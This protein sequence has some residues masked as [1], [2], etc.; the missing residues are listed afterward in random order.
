MDRQ[1]VTHESHTTIAN[2]LRFHAPL[3]T[4]VG[5]KSTEEEKTRLYSSA[6]Q[7]TSTSSLTVW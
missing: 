6:S 1:K 7:R 2:E 3:V 5:R 4:V